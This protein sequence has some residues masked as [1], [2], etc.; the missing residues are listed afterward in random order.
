M[1]QGRVNHVGKGMEATGFWACLRNRKSVVLLEC[2]LYKVVKVKVGEKGI[3]NSICQEEFVYFIHVHRLQNRH[4]ITCTGSKINRPA[5]S[6]N[7]TMLCFLLLFP[8]LLSYHGN[9]CCLQVGASVPEPNAEGTG[10]EK[11][12]MLGRR[13]ISESKF[14]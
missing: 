9:L 11:K 4:K 14:R 10:K 3:I 6:R 12:I 1:F 8:F 5:D 7:Q 2:S 13:G